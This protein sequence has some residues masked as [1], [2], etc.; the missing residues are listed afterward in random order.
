[1]TANTPGSRRRPSTDKRAQVGPLA[2]VLGMYAAG[3]E[4]T[5]RHLTKLVAVASKVAGTQIPLECAA[6]HDRPHRR[7]RR[8]LRRAARGAAEPV[9]V[10]GRQHRQGRHPHLQPAD[11]PQGRGA[12]LRLPRGAARRAV[13]LGGDQGR[14][15]RQLPGGGAV[16]LERRPARR[17]TTSPAHTRPRWS[18][19]PVADPDLPLEVLRTVHSFDPCIACAVHLADA[20][21]R[22]IV[23]VKA[24]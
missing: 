11:L 7:P 19:N 5:R 12:R 14:Q 6:F 22:P 10:A 23:Q 9:A 16:H 24:M 18:D 4:P 17:R 2:N 1:M 21:K 8:A 15:D 20:D 3:H 13:A